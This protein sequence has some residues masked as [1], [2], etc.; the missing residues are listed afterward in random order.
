[1]LH[2]NNHSNIL[3][4]QNVYKTFNIKQS[5][6]QKK[7]FYAVKDLSLSLAQVSCLGLL[8]E[9]G[10]RKTTL[11]LIIVGLLAAS[12]GKILFKGEELY[13]V[14]SREKIHNPEKIQMVFQ[15]PFSSL[16]PRKCVGKSISEPLFLSKK[17]LSKS[18]IIEKTH[19]ILQGVGLSPIF[20]QRFPHEFSGGQRQRIALAR[21]L[22]T[23]PEIIVCDEPVSALD[24]S[25]QAQV[26]NLMKDFQRKLNLSYI[27]I[28]HD[29][30]VVAH[31]SSEIVIMYLGQIVEKAKKRVFLK[32]L[33]TLILR[34]F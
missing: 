3:E 18:E 8:G 28:S 17:E 32:I 20:Y 26:L 15:D 7:I 2:N 9:S 21:A 33:L 34:H 23:K 25:V 10:C 14:G 4:L 24:V 13:T 19:E 5:W 22:I 27:F 1:M 11:A 31:M 30:H 29:L 6:G 16:N 12:K